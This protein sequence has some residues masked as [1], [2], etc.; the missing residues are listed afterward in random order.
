MQHLEYFLL[1]E[2]GYNGE[3]DRKEAHYII[4][5]Y[6]CFRETLKI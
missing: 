3:Y 5:K 1:P 4:K 2:A 6:L